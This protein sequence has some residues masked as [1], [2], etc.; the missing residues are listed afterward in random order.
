MLERYPDEPRAVHLLGLALGA[1][2]KYD[3]ATDC[4]CRSIDLAPDE[5]FTADFLNN[6]GSVLGRYGH[7][8]DAADCFRRAL[9]LRPG[10]ARAATNL[11][12]AEA[13]AR[14]ADLS[15]CR[16]RGRIPGKG[17]W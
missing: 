3:A 12:A 16:K 9:H 2:R 4:L 8:A 5:P 14:P 11:R 13:A 1:Q 6:L 7:P 10:F 17:L 15:R